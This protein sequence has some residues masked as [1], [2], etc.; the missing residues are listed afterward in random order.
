MIYLVVSVSLLDRYLSF[1]SLEAD[2]FAADEVPERNCGIYTLILD[3]DVNYVG[4]SSRRLGRRI[5]HHI[6]EGRIP[7][8]F[9]T[10]T[11]CPG[12]NGTHGIAGIRICPTLCQIETE[13]I[14]FIRPPYNRT[15]RRT[16]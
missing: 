5:N 16:R 7:F 4:R 2:V 13:L 11:D 8:E 1:N 9:V 6:E 15:L 3:E 12:S 10:L 14:H